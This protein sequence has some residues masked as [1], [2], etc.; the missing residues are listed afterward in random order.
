MKTGTGRRNLVLSSFEVD[1][2]LFEPLVVSFAAA[3]FLFIR[4]R[5]GFTSAYE[6]TELDL[7]GYQIS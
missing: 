4:S 1:S 7:F 6:P 3:S 5:F 2:L